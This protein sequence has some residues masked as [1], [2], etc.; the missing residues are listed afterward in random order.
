MLVML[1]PETTLPGAHTVLKRFTVDPN[2]VGVGWTLKIAAY[3]DHTDVVD[4]LLA[5]TEEHAKAGQALPRVIKVRASEAYLYPA[6]P[7][8]AAKASR[9]SRAKRA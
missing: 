4:H 9:R 2:E 3:P 5:R 1:L 8:A 6:T 7:A